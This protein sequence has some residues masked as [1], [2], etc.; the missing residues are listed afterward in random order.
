MHKP[1]IVDPGTLYDDTDHKLAVMVQNQRRALGALTQYNFYLCSLPMVNPLQEK[2]YE[3]YVR[4]YEE[5]TNKIAE[6]VEEKKLEQN[7]D[8]AVPIRDNEQHTEKET[9]CE[10]TKTRCQSSDEETPEEARQAE[11]EDQR[12]QGE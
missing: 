1:Q 8:S 4:Q 7:H 6:Y 5:I 10:K 3:L 12:P 11:A 2:K 9:N